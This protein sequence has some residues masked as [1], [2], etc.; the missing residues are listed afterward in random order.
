MPLFLLGISRRED[1]TGLPRHW[2]N[3]QPTTVPFLPEGT[4]AEPYSSQIQWVEYGQLAAAT[5]RSVLGAFKPLEHAA[6]LAAIHTH[7]SILPVRYGTVLPDEEAIR[8]FLTNRCE[9]L[10]RDLVRVE[11]AVEVGLRIDLA[12]PG[13]QGAG[14][15]EQGVCN[16]DS[17]TRHPR[18]GTRSTPPA[19]NSQLPASPGQYLA[20]R[21]QRYESKDRLDRQAQLATEDFVQAM[22]GLY[23][24]WR[25]LTSTVPA[26]VRLAFLVR[27][28]SWKTF[29][30]RL[31]EKIRESVSPRET[32]Q[33]SR[34]STLLGPWP[35]YS[36]VSD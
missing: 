10:L 1:I 16:A 6:L 7:I 29:R 4:I 12:E 28:E 15:S 30:Q 3:E 19:P 36:F 25:T 23:C 26:V 33:V 20:L 34:R 5:V 8:H 18:A 11:G 22:R 21:R 14:S 31:E 9:N 13:K 35:P 17:P 2:P 32:E 24:E 27:R